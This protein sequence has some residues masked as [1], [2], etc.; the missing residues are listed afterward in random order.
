MIKIYKRN[1]QWVGEIPSLGLIVRNGTEKEII[2]SLC[3][4]LETFL[5]DRYNKGDLL[6]ILADQKEK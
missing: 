5:M 6:S 4:E 2:L 1:A 3:F